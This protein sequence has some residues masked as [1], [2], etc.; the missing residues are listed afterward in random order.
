MIR[1]L[2]LVFALSVFLIR[3]LAPALASGVH[4]TIL[5]ADVL[6]LSSRRNR[7]NTIPGPISSESIYSFLATSA[8]SSNDI[9]AVGAAVNTSPDHANKTLT[10]HWDGSY[11]SVINSA[12]RES[13]DVLNAVTAISLND[14]WAV[15]SIEG[16]DALIERWN[17]SEWSIFPGPTVNAV[18]YDIAQVPDSNQLWAVGDRDGT[19]SF[20]EHW[21]G[22][23]WGVVPTPAPG[24]YSS[25]NSVTAIAENNVWAVGTYKSTIKSLPQTLIEHWNGSEWSIVPSPNLGHAGWLKKVIAVPGS[26]KLWAVGNAIT[27]FSTG[28]ERTLIEYWNGSAWSIVPSPNRKPENN[29]TTNTLT[30][31]TAVSAN[32]VW[33][34]GFYQRVSGSNTSPQQPLIEHWNGISWT[35]V[36]SPALYGRGVLYNITRIP[37]TQTLWAVGGGILNN[38]YQSFAASYC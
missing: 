32:D 29:L 21:N 8:L 35:V 27:D 3:P 28:S 5:K 34:V 25:L 31:A 10:A 22:V 24:T 14:V 26:P 37:K 9:W 18:L 12:N 20:A 6:S 30:G 7:W 16:E 15:G 11:W 23:S 4:S 36:S 1:I 38:S 17:G 33:A 2:C 13:E 19:R